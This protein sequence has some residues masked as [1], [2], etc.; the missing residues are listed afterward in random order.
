MDFILGS[1]ISEH[2]TTGRT[3]KTTEVDD[4]ASEHKTSRSVSFATDIPTSRSKESSGIVKTVAFNRAMLAPTLEQAINH[5]TNARI[6]DEKLINSI[7]ATCNKYYQPANKPTVDSIRK[8]LIEAYIATDENYGIEAAVEWANG[9][10]IPSSA[11]A[12]DM[13][14]FLEAGLDFKVM[15]Q[16]QIAVNAASRLSKDRVDRLHPNNPERNKLHDLSDGMIIP[17]CPSFVPNALG[18][19]TPPRELYLK[20][21]TAVDKMLFSLHEQGL[22]FILPKA[23]ALKYIPNLNCCK[24]H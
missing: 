11:V 20:V 9:F 4:D 7:V 21:H 17:H 23:E 8:T 18:E 10:E 15:V 16:Q 13:K 14:K 6:T 12:S 2:V 5:N 24:A 3:R 1:P 22:A 19:T